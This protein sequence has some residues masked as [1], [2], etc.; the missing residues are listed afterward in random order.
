MILKEKGGPVGKDEHS[1]AGYQQEQDVPFY[2]RREFGV[3][4]SVLIINDLRV[5]YN[6]EHARK[7]GTHLI[8]AYTP[9]H[10]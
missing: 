7:K 9:R 8:F 4:P 10:P 5:E 1:K 3:D 6:G 2:L